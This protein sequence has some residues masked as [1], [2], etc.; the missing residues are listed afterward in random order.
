MSPEATVP[1][2]SLGYALRAFVKEGT[3]YKHVER[4]SPERHRVCAGKDS[5]RDPERAIS[6]DQIALNIEQSI[7]LIAWFQNPRTS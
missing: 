5:N 7:G 1:S 2:S 3:T 4:R 6:L